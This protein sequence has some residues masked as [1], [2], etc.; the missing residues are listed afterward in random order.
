MFKRS[1]LLRATRVLYSGVIAFSVV[2]LLMIA[3][4]GVFLR[5][6]GLLRLGAASHGVVARIHF[7][8]ILSRMG[9][10]LLDALAIF[11]IATIGVV[12]I[13]ILLRRTQFLFDLLGPKTPPPVPRLIQPPEVIR[14]GRDRGA[15]VLQFRRR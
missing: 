4:T 12:L 10:V 6:A 3:A 9:G 2:Y 7:A 11:W 14:D 15:K 1:H 8:L 5:H 13:L